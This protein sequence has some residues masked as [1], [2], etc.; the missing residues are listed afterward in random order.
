MAGIF[1]A[2][3]LTTVVATTVV[4]GMGRGAEEATWHPALV[5]VLVALVNDFGVYWVHRWHHRVPTIW[6]FHAVHHSAEVLTPVTVYRKHP[7]YDVVSQLVRSL[8]IGLLQG[9]VLALLIGKV[10]MTVI[11]GTNVVYVLF[12][13]AGSNLRHSHLWLRYGAVIEHVLISPAQHQI[14]H[15]RAV[16]HKDTNYGEIFAVWDWMFGTLYV[17]A[18]REALEFGLSDDTGAAIEQPHG[19]LT[20]AL[21]IPF[22]DSWRAMSPRKRKAIIRAGIEPANE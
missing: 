11:A 18:G 12:N 6:S 2:V 5:A 10:E 9:L 21:L 8:L 15:S 17:P 7:V 20:Q 13:L 14:H 16:Q 3:S 4:A 19:S 22:R 1:G